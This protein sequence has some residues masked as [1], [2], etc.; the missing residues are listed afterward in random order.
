MGTKIGD[1][2]I[3]YVSIY[4]CTYICIHPTL[5]GRF[6]INYLLSGRGSV[7]SL[8]ERIVVGVRPFIFLSFSFPKEGRQST[9]NPRVENSSEHVHGYSESQVED[10]S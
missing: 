5:P 1:C 9:A 4:V 2:F 8:P 7:A 10:L 3:E 6:R